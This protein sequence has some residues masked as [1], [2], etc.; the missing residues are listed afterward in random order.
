MFFLFQMNGTKKTEGTK[1]VLGTIQCGQIKDDVILN[2]LNSKEITSEDLTRTR[3]FQPLL[4]HPP[5]NGVEGQNKV[6]SNLK[7]IVTDWLDHGEKSLRGH[8][9]FGGPIWH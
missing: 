3:C 5:K 8:D 1:K 2:E 7:L 9:V 4:E 6:Y